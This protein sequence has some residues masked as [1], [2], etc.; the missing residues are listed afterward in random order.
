MSLMNTKSTTR[1][2]GAVPNLQRPT[3][4][5]L[6]AGCGGLTLGFVNQGFEP[7]LALEDNATAVDTYQ[8]HF[9]DHIRCERIDE[10]TK[11]PKAEVVVGGPPCQGFSSAGLRREGD[12]RNSL[13]EVFARIVRA[14]RPEAFV[15]E[16]VEGFFTTDGGRRV[17]D[18]LGPLIDSGYRIH[19]RKINAANFG[20]PQHRKRV[21]AIG[22]RGWDPT[23][24]DA[25]HSAYGSPGAARGGQ[26]YPKTPTVLDAIGDLAAAASTPPGE[27]EDHYARPLKSDRHRRLRGLKPGE[28]MR[29]LPER[30]WHGSYRRRA[31]RRVMDGIPTERRGG[32]P[33]GMRRLRGDQPS[34]AITGG[35]RSEFVHPVEDRFLTLRECA[36][37]QTFPDDFRF[38]GSEAEK[39]LLIAN[40]VPPRLAGAIAAVLAEDLRTRPNRRKPGVLLTFVP[41]LAEGMSPALRKVTEEVEAE[42]TPNASQAPLPL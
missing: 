5:D 24:P 23:F 37:I 41:T 21:I 29:D 22:A 34:K 30:Y 6:F 25:T 2:R 15:F 39:A 31:F 1:R 17:R 12:E 36:R 9:G 7:I 8:A 3:V 42:F 27:P 28:T 32:A 38:T 40:A 16:N 14:S 10:Y 19:L 26:H 35:A 20:V 33:A 4:V 13:V 18:L 11:V